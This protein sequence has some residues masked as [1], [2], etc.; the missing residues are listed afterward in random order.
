MSHSNDLSVSANNE[1]SR[2]RSVIVGK[3][4]GSCFPSESERMIKA[5]MPEDHHDQFKPSK[6]FPAHVVQGACQELERFAAILERE[7]IKTYRP[8]TIRW[9]EV[10]GY[11]GAMPRDGMLVVGNTIIEACYAWKC[12]KQEIRLAF[13]PVLDQ[14]EK[15]ANVRVVRAP[16]IPCPDPLYE[17]AETKDQPGVWAINN[18]RAAFD[19]AD[20]LRFGK[21][22]IGQLSNVTN[23]K[24]VEYIQ[25]AVPSGYTVELLQVQD[26][27]AMHIDATIVPLREGLL[28]YNP[29]RVSE[30][31]LRRHEVL[32]EWK[33]LAC[34]IIPTV[35]VSPPLYMTSPWI[36]LNIL[37]LD[38]KRVV[39]EAE[40][41][42]F[43]AWLVELG[44]EP[45]F[46]PFR[47][48]N[49]IGGSFHCATVDLVRA[50]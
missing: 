39:V 6:P 20:F 9:S 43:A 50:D 30:V 7:D 26:P 35:R 34:P 31:S 8:R 3:A 14:L 44:M 37:S 33:L 18:S 17:D 45:I 21:T 24:G 32:A 41:T 12:R 22:L 5:T 40:E 42:E 29:E 2:L 27:H 16:E 38:E 15:D 25:Q 10:G 1:W 46:C 49:S 28:I 47:H 19:A 48:V 4:E 11:T 36:F 13:G 23:M